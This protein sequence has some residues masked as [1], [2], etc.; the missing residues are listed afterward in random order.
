MK[1]RARPLDRSD[2][3]PLWAQLHDDLV[4]RL[5]V[6]AFA[7][8]F[9]GEHEL[10]GEYGVSRHTVREALRRLRDE[11][12]VEFGR[13]RR[14][15]VRS[16]AIEQPLGSLYSLFR[17]VEDTG[18]HQRSEVSE[19]RLVTDADVAARLDLDA[20]AE[21]VHLARVRYA[22][23]QPLACDRAWLPAELARPLLEA[24]FTHSSL[25]NELAAR[26]GVQPDGGTERIS[27]TTPD[28]RLRELLGLPRGVACL[29]I[30]RVGRLGSQA[31]EF[32]ITEIRGDR[33]AVTTAWSPRGYRVGAAGREQPGEA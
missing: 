27:A 15:M 1:P 21:L 19:L 9:P 2:P 10:A 3:A 7:D 20:D 5:R 24:D 25:Y 22:D 11:G 16:T 32:R 28:P 30:E 23:D 31:I 8:A 26:C 18:M 29:S 6:G 12:V 33:Y 14:S 17:V 4:R 13:G